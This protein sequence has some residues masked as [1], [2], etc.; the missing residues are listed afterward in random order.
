[1]KRPSRIALEV[2][3][4]PLLAAT[5]LEIV[6]LVSVREVGALKLFILFVAFAYFFAGIPSVLFAG[7]MELAFSA[8][9]A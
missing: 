4:P 5:I 7:L 6:A 8:R 2:L 9:R 1:M 3:G